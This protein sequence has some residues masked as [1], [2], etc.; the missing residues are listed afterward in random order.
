M[1]PTF[2]TG[3]FVIA[4]SASEYRVG[5]IV[6]F[7]TESADVIH[8]IVGGNAEDGFATRGDNKTNE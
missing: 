3:D 8:R 2:V 4:R 1:E 5:D 7:Q 6:V